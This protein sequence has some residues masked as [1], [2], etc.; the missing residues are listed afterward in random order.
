MITKLKFTST[1]G[2]QSTSDTTLWEQKNTRTLTHTTN[3]SKPR[4]LNTKIDT[5]GIFCAWS[6]SL[7][8]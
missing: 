1:A 4:L 5:R 8:W 3:K 7:F 2:S 6:I